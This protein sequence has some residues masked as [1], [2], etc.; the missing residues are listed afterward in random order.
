[1]YKD[2]FGVFEG[3]QRGCHTLHLTFK[4]SL[5]IGDRPQVKSLAV[6][7]SWGFFL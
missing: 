6:G 1:M 5:A 7:E 3:L 4:A 2:L